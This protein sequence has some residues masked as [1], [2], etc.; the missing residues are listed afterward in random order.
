MKNLKQ[1]AFLILGALV[2]S[3]SAIS[4]K[5][6]GSKPGNGNDNTGAPHYVDPQL[7]GSWM[8]TSGSDGAYYDDNGVYHGAAYGFATKFTV[9]TNGYGTCFNHV[10]SDLGYGSR[11]VVD[12]SYKGYF[13]MDNQGNL[14]FY[15][16][17]GT[18]KSS[19]G[20]NRP[21]SGDELYNASTG[22]GRVLTYPNVAFTTL[23]GRECFTLTF[24]DNETDVFYKM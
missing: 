9:N 6:D 7:V 17:S 2:L 14:S 24:S 23:G 10:F 1:I 5:K 4:C 21:L 3:I 12:I 11:L 13:E 20:T 16:T 18:Y 22:T 15:P 19:S 8:W